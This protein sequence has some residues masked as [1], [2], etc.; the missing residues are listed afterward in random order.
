M[1]PEQAKGA[2]NVDH[3][4]DIYSVGVILYEA[5]TGQVPFNAETF[6][7][8]IFKIALESPP[9][10]EQFVPNLD[11]QFSAIMKRAM[12]REVDVRFQSAA[13]MRDTLLAWAHGASAATTAGAG[14][15]TVAL[16]MPSGAPQGQGAF[17]TIAL[18]GPPTAPAARAMSGGT[19]ALGQ[20]PTPSPGP[21]AYGAQ[22][23]GGAAIGGHPM[24]APAM[25]GG[26]PHDLGAPRAPQK[27]GGTL[28][29]TIAHVAAR[30]SLAVM[31][32]LAIVGLF[33]GGGLYIAYAITRAPAKTAH[34]S[35]GDSVDEGATA[36][37][38]PTSATAEA[39]AAPTAAPPATADA[40]P[41][42]SAVVVAGDPGASEHG[43]APAPTS[44]PRAGLTGRLPGAATA[45]TAPGAQTAKP[46]A[47]AAGPAPTGRSID[48][49]L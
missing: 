31:I 17:G 47:T 10:P 22:A 27:L 21:V 39:P 43:G 25:S 14:G 29:G 18:A 19:V 4:A 35:S 9:P 32:I 45:P 49:S 33:A 24:G 44:T 46:T 37:P 42:A 16:A 48:D 6:N 38:R 30:P 20:G 40:A 36:A 11:P 1:S 2:R 5:I 34:T 7:E 3:R 15:A 23:M 8:L 12:A 26:A 13:E 28:A 41:T